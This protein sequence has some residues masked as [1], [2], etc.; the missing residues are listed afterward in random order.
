MVAAVHSLAEQTHRVSPHRLLQNPRFFHDFIHDFESVVAI[1]T[2]SVDE[3]VEQRIR[4]D[5]LPFL[6]GE[7]EH[8]RVML[9]EVEHHEVDHIFDLSIYQVA[10]LKW[11]SR[12]L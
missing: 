8:H 5:R 9:A 12:F 4:S 10:V 6:A 2:Q 3:F 1:F 7:V 11:I